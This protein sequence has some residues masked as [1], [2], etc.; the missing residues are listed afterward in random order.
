MYYLPYMRQFVRCKRIGLAMILLFVSQVL[1]VSIASADSSQPPIAEQMEMAHCMGMNDAHRDADNMPD[2][3]NVI[4]AEDRCC[5][6]C[7]CFLGS[8]SILPLGSVFEDLQP[9]PDAV[10]SSVVSFY[11]AV[12]PITLLRPPTSN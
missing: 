7:S 11:I 6:E 2:A 9:Q 5:S 4:P 3:S 10:S 1:P 12:S 8:C